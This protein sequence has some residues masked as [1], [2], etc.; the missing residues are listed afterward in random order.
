MVQ[1]AFDIR[2]VSRHYLEGFVHDVEVHSINAL[3][4]VKITYR[5]S[6]HFFNFNMDICIGIKMISFL[7]ELHAARTSIQC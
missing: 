2:C 5:I 4:R 7:R 1:K 3:Q 6:K